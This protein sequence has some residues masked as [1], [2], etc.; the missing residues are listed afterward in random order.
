M[1]ILNAGI[2]AAVIGA[3]LYSVHFLMLRAKADTVI[4]NL[5]IQPTAQALKDN[6]EIATLTQ[7]VQ[8]AKVD[9]MRARDE[10]NSSNGPTKPAG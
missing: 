10:F 7:E 9:Y 4:G 2:V 1:S 3:V 8:D 5:A 6:A